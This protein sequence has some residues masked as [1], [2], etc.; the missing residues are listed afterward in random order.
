MEAPSTTARARSPVPAKIPYPNITNIAT[1]VVSPGSGSDWPGRQV[2]D[3]DQD[4]DRRHTCGQD[5]VPRILESA[6]QRAEESQREGSDARNQRC[7]PFPLKSHEQTHTQGDAK[8]EERLIHGT[9]G[10]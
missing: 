7:G 9:K 2:G 5:E 3:P 10:S 4:R 1:S 6:A 8:I